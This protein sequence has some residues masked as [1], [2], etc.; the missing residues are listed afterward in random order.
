MS[1]S[2][3]RGES[4]FVQCV[5]FSCHPPSRGGGLGYLPASPLLVLS[6]FSPAA[7]RVAWAGP[8]LLPMVHSAVTALS[9]FVFPLPF[10]GISA[11]PTALWPRDWSGNVCSTHCQ[12]LSPFL[13]HMITK[14]AV[15]YQFDLFG[16]PSGSGFTTA[17]FFGNLHFRYCCSASLFLLLIHGPLIVF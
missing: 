10:V 2:H 1:T 12:S 5:W 6:F 14:V 15:V 11:F 7:G 16:L 3:G 9:F 17:D 8:N 4:C 13:E